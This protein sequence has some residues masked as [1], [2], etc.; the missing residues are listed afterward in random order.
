M[1][2]SDKYSVRQD[3]QEKFVSILEQMTKSLT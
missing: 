1:S 3:L 2:L